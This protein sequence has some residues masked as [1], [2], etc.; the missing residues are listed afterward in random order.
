MS[1]TQSARRVLLA[2]LAVGAALTAA[3]GAAA[4]DKLAQGSK[5]PILKLDGEQVEMIQTAPTDGEATVIVVEFWATWCG[6][7][8]ASIPH[9]N[10]IYA[11][12]KDRGLRVYGVSDETREK[13]EPFVKQKGAGMSYSIVRDK[14]K[15]ISAAFMT[16][17]GMQG[18]PAAFVLSTGPDAKVL[19]IG[20]PHPQADG[21]RLE[22][23]ISKAVNGRYDP[24][25]TP[26]GELVVAAAR[27]AAKERNWLVVNSTLQTL[28]DSNP[29][30]FLDAAVQRYTYLLKDQ[31]DPAA[32]SAYARELLDKYEG[33]ND[34]AA[35]RDLAVNFSTASDLPSHD[36]EAALAASTKFAD[37]A[38]DG[39]P[40]VPSTYATVLAAKGDL[41]G[42]IEK[43]T[44]AW[45]MASPSAKPS[46]KRDLDAYKA[47]QKRGDAA[48]KAPSNSGTGAATS[49][50][51][52]PAGTN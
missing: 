45:R 29:R 2:L 36:Y 49:G 26:K 48:A 3:P 25:L 34:S 16:A 51:T 43:Q 18:I 37:L 20:N 41:S 1:S 12:F 27:K 46:Y 22:E 24:E 39:D 28:V 9:L 35:L 21:K 15:S 31:N 50:S 38:G 10:D 32:A 40:R 4:Q 6:P 7:C 11:K 17:A 30:L 33:I 42:A 52:P 19:F 8:K 13:I 5:A 14:D 47:A 44:A 23:V